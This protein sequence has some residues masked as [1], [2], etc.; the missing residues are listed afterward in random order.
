MEED[1]FLDSIKELKKK[2]DAKDILNSKLSQIE[3]DWLMNDWD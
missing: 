2:L 3:R 1:A